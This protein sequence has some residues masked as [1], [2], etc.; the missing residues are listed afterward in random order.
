MLYALANAKSLPKHKS[1]E[2]TRDYLIAQNLKEELI[3][4]KKWQW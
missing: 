3:L 4:G 1:T 2:E